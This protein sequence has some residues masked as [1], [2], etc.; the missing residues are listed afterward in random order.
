MCQQ[1]HL[2][3][4]S[5]PAA[6]QEACLSYLRL[7][8][9]DIVL[10][11][12]KFL[13]AG[14]IGYCCCLVIRS[15]PTLCDP[16]DCSPPSSFVHGISQARVLHGLLF[17]SPGDLPDPG[18]EPESPALTGGFFTNE[19]PGK[20]GNIGSSSQNEFCGTFFLEDTQQKRKNSTFKYTTK[21]PVLH[22]PIT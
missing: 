15:C 1:S 9:W 5:F 2:L 14:G 20:P 8:P 12:E 22:R 4:N 7:L 19:P 16:M 13:L 3:K 21:Q 18:I 10:N 6:I 17:P 11:L